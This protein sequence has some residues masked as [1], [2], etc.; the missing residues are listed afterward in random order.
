MLH[1]ASTY[2]FFCTVK[3]RYAKFLLVC[4]FVSAA[5]M[6]LQICSRTPINFWCL[7]S[8]SL[9]IAH[10]LLNVL[11]WIFINHFSKFYISFL[12]IFAFNVY[13]L[14]FSSY[15]IRLSFF[16][17]IHYYYTQINLNKFLFSRSLFHTIFNLFTNLINRQTSKKVNKRRATMSSPKASTSALDDD[18]I[19]I[20]QSI[21]G[22]SLCKH[23]K[24]KP[25]LLSFR[26]SL[27]IRM[28]KILA[29]PT[30]DK[31]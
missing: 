3:L 29:D 7:S 25:Y 30:K 28:N 27:T 17:T 11:F 6:H 13:L 8:S 23:L 2:I 19:I 21:N 4:P 18:E 14:C 20:C 26:F 16:V 10:Q 1:V 24:F 9:F 22:L 5:P 15:C 31:V 12:F